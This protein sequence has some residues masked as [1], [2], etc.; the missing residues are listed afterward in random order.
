MII[1]TKVP[2][3]SKM[4]IPWK[5]YHAIVI[6]SDFHQLQDYETMTKIFKNI[7]FHNTSGSKLYIYIYIIVCKLRLILLRLQELSLLR[8]HGIHGRTNL[9]SDGV[10]NRRCYSCCSRETLDV[11][12]KKPWKSWKGRLE[13][14]GNHNLLACWIQ[15]HGCLSPFQMSGA[16]PPLCCRGGINSGHISVADK[17]PAAVQDSSEKTEKQ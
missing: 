2:F 11:P 10:T 8:V 17:G 15:I 12:E 14:G 3:K 9:W 16:G 5:N 4:D 1:A 13:A 6:T 7:L